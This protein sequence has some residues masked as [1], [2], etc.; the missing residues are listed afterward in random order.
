MIMG[1]NAKKVR[2]HVEYRPTTAYV[3]AAGNGRPA[4]DDA[5]RVVYLASVSLG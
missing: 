3:P 1:E 2:F 4:F 5:L